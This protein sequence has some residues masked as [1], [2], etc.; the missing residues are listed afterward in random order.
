MLI[1]NVTSSL[2]AYIHIQA[3]IPFHLVLV[4]GGLSWA[5]VRR[6]GI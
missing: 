4:E 1:V 6:W 2:L 5:E 3:H